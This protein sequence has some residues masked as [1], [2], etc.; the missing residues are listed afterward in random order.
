VPGVLLRARVRRFLVGFVGTL[1]V[2]LLAATAASVAIGLASNGRVLP[3]VT[4]GGVPLGGLD[5]AA[6]EARLATSLP[7]LSDGSATLVI[8]G[9]RVEVPYAQLGRRYDLAAM[10]DAAM[11]TG[12]SAN[13]VSSAI[14]RL[15]DAVVGTALPVQ[16]HA[17]DAAA[18]DAVAAA[19]AAEHSQA[20]ADALARVAAGGIIIATPARDGTSVD[21]ATVRRLLGAAVTTSRPGDVTVQ[22]PVTTVSPAVSTEQAQA[23]VRVA[24]AMVYTPLTLAVDGDTVAVQP[25]ELAPLLRFST[26]ASGQYAPAID[27]TALNALVLALGSSIDRQPVDATYRYGATIKV[28]PAVTGRELGRPGTAAAIR[29]A[30][31]DRAAGG[32]P[33]PVTV[34]VSVTAPNLTTAQAQASVAKIVRIGTWTTYFT[35]Y[36]ENGYGAN[37]II[38]AKALNGMVVQ[39]GETFDFWK[40]I[41]PITAA[42]GY[43][44]GGAII[45]GK[46]ELTGALGGGICSTSTTMFNAAL[47]AG[48]EMG[49]R[50]NH[51]Y[52]LSRYPVGLDATVYD[53]GT[54]VVDMTWTNDTPYPIIIRSYTGYGWVRFDLYSVPTGRK[55]TLTT[56]VITNRVTAHDVVQ[57]TT[58]LAPGVEHRV[59]WV[60]NGFDAYV[61]RYVRD[62]SGALIH[63]DHYYSH[64]AAV[65]GLLLIGKSAS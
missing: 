52:Y 50:T 26:D 7:S 13:P 33:G 60:A 5:R 24:Q 55:V 43:L 30:L 32:D 29:Q 41:G 22:I 11:G 64:Y 17:Y 12:R 6:A 46:T 61:T 25:D 42:K 53:S 49:A 3:G 35:V 59:E 19:V 45:N 27:G 36:I 47:R 21:P 9:Q 15:R 63:V 14:A 44:P 39:P 18:L 57:Y 54:S 10:V 31:D 20:P 56:P 58:S 34:P 8:E 65:N 37:I 62:A 1:L 48:L 40:A 2:A 28:V 23:A 51:Y 38:P 16:V 4:I